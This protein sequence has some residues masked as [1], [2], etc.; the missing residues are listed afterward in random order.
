MSKIEAGKIE[1]ERVP[2]VPLDLVAQIEAVYSIQ[3]QEKG[4]EFEVMTSTGCDV[5]RLGDPHRVQQILHN[6]LNNAIK[7]T[8]AGTIS[9]KFSCR[10][11][12]PVVFEVSDTG[13]G[14]TSDQAARVFDSF[15]QADSSM[16]RRFGGTGL[17]LSIVR[18]LARLM[19]GD[20]ALTSHPGQ[21]TSVRVT[22][23]LPETARPPA[24]RPVAPDMAAQA[25]SFA[26]LR[27]L[28]ADDSA[29]N[30]EVLA[31]ML[32]PSGATIEQAE[33]GQQALDLWLQARRAGTPYDIVLLDITMP[34][35]DGLS[36]LTELRQIEAA[37]GCA[38]VPVVAVTANA[39]PEQVTEYVMR[40]FDT[41]LS[42]PFSRK[43]LLHAIASLA[44]VPSQ[45]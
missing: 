45:S 10:P 24:A 31:K 13:V 2:M 11:G 41:H 42:K 38:P 20:V 22:L 39:M 34:V 9:L 14:M 18:E 17:G 1:L 44:R 16:T 4:I 32:H 15:E 36:T 43:D 30:R 27:I 21:G 19:G 37:Q 23:P 12:K 5:P 26:G 40:G 29:T 35:R 6:L 25:L 7:F 28:N 8:S 33:N 3:A